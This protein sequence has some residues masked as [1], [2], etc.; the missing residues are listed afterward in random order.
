MPVLSHPAVI[1]TIATTVKPPAKAIT[2]RRLGFM[3]PRL[4]VPSHG[5]EVAPPYRSSI[6][7]IT[8]GE[9]LKVFDW[10]VSNHS[11]IVN[12]PQ[13]GH[14]AVGLLLA[15]PRLGSMD[16]GGSSAAPMSTY[17]ID[18]LAADLDEVLT[19]LTVTAR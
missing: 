8:S 5:K 3:S 11:W 18:R 6:G 10:S 19:A 16:H 4:D 13:G 15:L 17:R 12:N 7:A 14:P 2:R 9:T 1:A